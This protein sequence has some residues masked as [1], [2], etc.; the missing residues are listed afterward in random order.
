MSQSVYVLAGDTI[1]A[2][3]S[4]GTIAECHIFIYTMTPGKNTDTIISVDA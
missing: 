1:S 2:E 4:T 3:I